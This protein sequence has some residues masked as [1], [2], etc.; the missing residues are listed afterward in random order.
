VA[1]VKAEAA[2]WDIRH[3]ELALRTGEVQVGIRGENV[4]RHGRVNLL[5]IYHG[6]EALRLSRLMPVLTHLGLQ[7]LDEQTFRIAPRMEQVRHGEMAPRK[8]PTDVREMFLH[9]FRVLRRDGSL[10]PAGRVAR[11]LTASIPSVLAHEVEDDPLNALVT[12]AGLDHHQVAILRAY[13]AYLHQLRGPWTQRTTYAALCDNPVPAACLVKLFEI[14]FDP[15]VEPETRSTIE[16]TARADFDKA[17]VAVAGIHEDQIL[18]FF[19]RLILA[20][21]RTNRYGRHPSGGPQAPI[22]LKLQC[23]AVPAMPEPRP[24]YEIFVHGPELEGVHLRSGKIAR[25]GIRWSSRVDD[26][27]MEILGLMRAQRTKNSVIVPVGAKGGFILKR[28]PQGAPPPDEV[29]RQYRAF[30]G[31]LLDVTDN[32]LAGAVVH[33]TGVV[34]H[35]EDDPYLV[36]AADRGT[37]TFSDV[38]NEIAESRSFWLGDAFASGGSRGFNHKKEGITARGAWE[39][40]S[41]HF[42][43][44]GVDPEKAAFTVAGVGDMSGDVFGNGML[45]S[46]NMLLLA[47][48]NHAHIFLDPDPDPA[49]SHEERRRL[50]QLPASAWTDYDL[51]KSWSAPS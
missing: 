31:A 46:R 21:V 4:Q 37:A 39:L 3:M 29:L 10:I 48:F 44:M 45:L 7:V 49:V 35:D 23:A 6:G 47:A 18:R 38:A 2:V 43:E 5:L 33:P 8:G 40:V 13:D 15:R 27:R 34:V 25:G 36:V 20:T 50:F 19:E 41:R 28:A 42:R 26:Y 9:T 16:V 24:L 12:K 51:G 22:A 14:R 32:I 30:I 1:Q 17:M 11:S